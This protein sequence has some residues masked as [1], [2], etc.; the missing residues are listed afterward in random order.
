MSSFN[1]HR[2]V[3]KTRKDHRCLGCQDLIPK[4]EKAIN[5]SGVFEGD[6]YNYYLCSPCE[7]VIKEHRGYFEEGFFPGCVNELK[8]ELA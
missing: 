7:I 3:N 2:K 4:G 1:N 8:S 6:F 5:N